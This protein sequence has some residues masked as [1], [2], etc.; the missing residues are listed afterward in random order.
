VAG[1]DVRVFLKASILSSGETQEFGVTDVCSLS[2]DNASSFSS[3]MGAVLLFFFNNEET[4]HHRFIPSLP[5]A[6]NGCRRTPYGLLPSKCPLPKK[7][8]L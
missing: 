4:F 5:L 8:L 7:S 1:T 3:I 2:E 6:G